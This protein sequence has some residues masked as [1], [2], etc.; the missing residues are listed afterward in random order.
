MRRWL[1]V[2]VLCLPATLW[3]ADGMVYRGEQTLW[4][5]TIW[6]GEV[7]IDGILTVAPG[8]VLE[9]RP[10]TVVRFTP[11]DSNGDGIGEHELF[12]QGTLFAVGT[13]EAPIRFTSTTAAPHPGAWGAI[14]VMAS[15]EDNRLEHVEVSY[16]YR[17]FHA[18]FA[19]ARLADCTFKRCVRGAQ[20]QESQVSMSRCRVE[21]NLN[22]LQFRDSQV[23][24]ADLTVQGSYW[25]VRGVHSRVTLV[26]AV[27]EGNLVNGIN[28]RDC[29]ASVRE[30]RIAGNR[31]GLYLQQSR[32]E[33]FGCAF[34]KNSEHG[35]FLEESDV[36][37]ANCRLAANGRA[38]LKWVASTGQ[39]RGNRFVNNGEYALINDGATPV[40]ARANW[41]GIAEAVGIARLIRD[42]ADLPRIGAVDTEN[43]LLASP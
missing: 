32:A 6:Q 7:L 3:A 22:G 40:D 34:E 27:I 19:K 25:G 28:L 38:G 11:F 1:L 41:W 21:D 24:L 26:R 35:I 13:I 12:I 43:F 14:N 15:E 29:D 39:L 31:K 17:G 37:V 9:I 23:E 20:F 5:D 4:Q 42:A 16:A 36:L 2:L 33:V 8:V 30:S 10:G 18:H